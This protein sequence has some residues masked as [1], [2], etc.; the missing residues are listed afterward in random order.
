MATKQ[1]YHTKTLCLT[2]LFNGLKNRYLKIGNW[3]IRCTK[4]KEI[5]L[6][7]EFVGAN[8]DVLSR[9]EIEKH[10]RSGVPCIIKKDLAK[11][12]NDCSNISNKLM[13]I[14]LDIA[15]ET[16]TFT[17][18]YDPGENDS[19]ESRDAFWNDMQEGLDRKKEKSSSN[20]GFQW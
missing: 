13:F 20:G 3:N 10:A 16:Y 4:D 6:E 11:E 7:K 5:E 2:M 18:A 14:A 15:G 12:V 8:L 17:A 1:A 19:K 9:V